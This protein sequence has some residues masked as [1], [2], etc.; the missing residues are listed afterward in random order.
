MNNTD[1][2]GYIQPLFKWWWL[3]TLSTAIA[4]GSSAMYTIKQPPA[5]LSRTTIMVGTALL[6]PN[7]SAGEFGLANQLAAAYT[8]IA[9][10]TAVRDATMAA[11][12][13]KALPDY[14]VR[15]V[16]NTQLIEIAV[17]DTIPA[18]AQLVAAE[19]GKQLIHE[20]PTG[21]TQQEHDSFIEEQLAQLEK[22]IA[23]T[24][25]EIEQQ[26]SLL[27]NMYSA[28]Q[29]ADAKN[30]IAALESKLST[31]QATYASMI[32]NS[33]H[34][35]T[36]TVSIM[37]PANL[38]TRPLGRG[39]MTHVLLAAVIGFAFSVSGA[40]LLEYLDDSIKSEDDARKILNL[41]ALGA[42]P[43]V[44][45][46]VTDS[47]KLIMATYQQ[48]P[49]VD[50]YYGLRLNLEFV[51]V[52]H[53]VQRL[54]VTS[55]KTQDGKSITAADLCIAMTQVGR[56]VILVDADFHRPSQHRLFQLGNHFGLSTA[57]L[58]PKDRL[59][60]FLQSTSIKGL[61]V[62]TSGPL[63]PNSAELIGSARL[64]E[65]LQQLQGMAEIVVIDSPPVT[66]TVDAS[67]LAT[68][69]DGVLMVISAGNT[70]RALASRAANTLRQVNARL[71]GFVLNG[72]SLRH[73][74]Y[75]L[76]YGHKVGSG[77]KK[78]RSNIEL[79]PLTDKQNESSLPH[80]EGGHSQPVRTTPFFKVHS[81]GQ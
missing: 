33:Q 46:I 53:P 11:L 7:P 43:K 36:N 74:N 59:A 14:S 67:I 54:L 40:Y 61:S 37:E 10:R 71:L 41:H 17:V 68:L 72:V 34:N 77:H 75:S 47:D 70:S 81:N 56:N 30:Q 13:L 39:L 55:P 9:T 20:S 25:Q 28:R 50:A 21:K 27:A 3:L 6:D 60:G 62:L 24:N 8:D 23:E 69:C 45:N 1:L 63:P 29:I 38:P 16:P 49:V 80:Q 4:V 76:D 66:A 22:S 35:T 12:Q 15:I 2:W 42:I 31:V 51:S 32:A 57:L 73:S 48:S 26:K 44:N 19:L 64:Q 5:Y 52:D 18:R 65:L 78:I 79:L 58:S